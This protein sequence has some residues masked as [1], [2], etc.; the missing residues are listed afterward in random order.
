MYFE[1]WQFKMLVV[2]SPT[3]VENTKT[4]YGYNFLV[5]LLRLTIFSIFLLCIEDTPGK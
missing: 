3:F 1:K 4:I 5:P 2:F